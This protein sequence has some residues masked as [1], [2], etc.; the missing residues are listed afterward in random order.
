MAGAGVNPG[1][2]YGA[3]DDFGYS[4]TDKP[5]EVFDLQATILERLGI[6]HERLTYRHQGRDYRLTDVFGKVIQDILV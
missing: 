1:F 5:V 2:V 4:V 3:T 6:D